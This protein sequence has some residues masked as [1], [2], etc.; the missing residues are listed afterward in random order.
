MAGKY[1]SIMIVLVLLNCVPSPSTRAA[2]KGLTKEAIIQ[3][4]KKEGKVSWASNLVDEEVREVNKAFQKEFPFI[5]VEYGRI[6]GIEEHERVISEMQAK[7]FSYDMIHVTDLLVNR[8]LE[9]KLLHEPMD[10]SGVFGVEP[11]IIHPK[12][13]G[14]AIGTTPAGITYN[15]HK[16]PKDRIPK[17]WD[18]CVDPFFAGKL[19]L[20][21]RP[22]HFISV[23]AGHGEEWTLEF[24]KKIAAN[25]PKWMSGTTAAD[26]LVAAGEVLIQCPAS[27]A[28]WYRQ[29]SRKPSFPVEFVFPQGPIL[30]SPSLLLSPLKGSSNLHAAILLTGWLATKGLY[31]T[32]TGRETVLDPGTRLGKEFKRKNREVK[33]AS[34]ELMAESDKKGKKI[35]EAWGFPKPER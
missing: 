7:I 9:L 6:R 24:A 34:W 21:V 19:A 10:W 8:Y 35:L 32:D 16:V 17:R 2:E 5:K 31:I 4:A 33:V 12:R 18:D 30:A 14:V 1:W 23:M 15:K 28:S 3:G 26:T 25:K 22:S 20:E 13:F 29:A 27:Y 11:R